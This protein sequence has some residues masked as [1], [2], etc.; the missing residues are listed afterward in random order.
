MK[1][2]YT[3]DIFL[4]LSW[5]K[6]CI[7]LLSAIRLMCFSDVFGGMA[8]ILGSVQICL[9]WKIRMKGNRN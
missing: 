9:P 8:K 5:A 6:W 4:Y 1:V 3:D 7:R 2:I